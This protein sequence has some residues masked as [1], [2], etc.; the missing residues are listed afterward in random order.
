[1]ADK[2]KPEVETSL[3]ETKINEINKVKGRFYQ[4]I[5]QKLGEL[6]IEG[7]RD[8]LGETGSIESHIKLI[9]IPI[10]LKPI[11]YFFNNDQLLIETSL[12]YIMYCLDLMDSE[13]QIVYNEKISK[14]ESKKGEFVQLKDL[15]SVHMNNDSEYLGKFKVPS[16]M[17]SFFL[18]WEGKIPNVTIFGLL[19]ILE[20]LNILDSKT[21]QLINTYEQYYIEV[22]QAQT[23]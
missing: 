11:F 22:Q 17:N 15:L 19:K 6:L 14:I 23:L 7:L 8:F 12:L 2:F 9:K 18:K 16:Y 1:M 20:W 4:V 5:K 10:I 3:L 21:L 13:L